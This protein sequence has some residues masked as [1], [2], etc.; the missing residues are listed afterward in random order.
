[1]ARVVAGIGVSHAPGMTAVVEWI[2]SGGL[3]IHG[4]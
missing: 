1:M 3:A 4:A 2:G